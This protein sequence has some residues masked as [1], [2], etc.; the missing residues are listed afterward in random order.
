VVEVT[1]SRKLEKGLVILGYFM[2]IAI[3]EIRNKPVRL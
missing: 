1:G 2:D 3:E